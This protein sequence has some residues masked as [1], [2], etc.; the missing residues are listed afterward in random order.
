[1]AADGQLTQRCG[2]TKAV[3]VFREHT[4]GAR[5][6][7]PL[8]SS[9]D[10]YP[11][12]TRPSMVDRFYLPCTPSWTS[13]SDAVSATALDH[14]YT[15]YQCKL[16]VVAAQTS[17]SIEE[18]LDSQTRASE[19]LSKAASDFIAEHGQLLVFTEGCQVL[20]FVHDN[21]L[22]AFMPHAHIDHNRDDRA[23]KEG[24]RYD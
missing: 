8:R 15:V 6:K 1:M 18:R 9:R 21:Q 4:K 5:S 7:A 20:I 14:F 12:H 3:K 11:R 16:P 23:E 22:F 13:S 24:A 10:R 17:P 2:R 19:I